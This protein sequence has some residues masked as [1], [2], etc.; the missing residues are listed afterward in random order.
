MQNRYKQNKNGNIRVH[1][2]RP[3]TIKKKKERK[4]KENVNIDSTIAVSENSLV[5][6][7]DFLG[8]AHLLKQRLQ[9]YG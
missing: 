3:H 5:H 7:H 9:R 2:K 1:S 4:K 8:R 6:F